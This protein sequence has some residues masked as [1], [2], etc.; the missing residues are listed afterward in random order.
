MSINWELIAHTALKNLP[1]PITVLIIAWWFRSDIRQ[2]LG[3]LKSFRG[4]QFRADFEKLNN[5]SSSPSSDI[6]QEPEDLG[7]A[8]SHDEE[9]SDFFNTQDLLEIADVR[10]TAA[11]VEAWRTLESTM[12]AKLSTYSSKEFDTKNG[13][14]QIS[15]YRLAR[16][17]QTHGLLSKAD[18]EIATELRIIRNKSAH[19]VDSEPSTQQAKQYIREAR[20][21][22]V[23]LAKEADT[24]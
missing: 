17:L 18:V 19:S 11:I 7:R 22:A 8:S 24:Y 9:P 20:R 12:I 1:W 14:K 6:S 23:K 15:G 16:A 3:R 4:G 2:I 10:P 13:R 5:L 21:L